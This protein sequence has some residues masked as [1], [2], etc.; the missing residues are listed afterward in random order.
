[1]PFRLALKPYFM[2]RLNGV[3]PL[4]TVLWRDMIIIGTAL[5]VL[6]GIAGIILLTSGADTALAMTVYFALIP[7]NL[8]LFFAVWRCS[9]RAPASEAM[10]ARLIAA[11]WLVL[12]IV[13]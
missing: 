7:W 8:F 10:T 13:M 6:T 11:I 4:R 3:A 9:E 1:M 12:V 2:S 5:N